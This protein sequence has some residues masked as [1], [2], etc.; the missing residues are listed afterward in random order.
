MTQAEISALLRK[1][2]CRVLR[3]HDWK[4]AVRTGAT[5]GTEKCRRCL[6]TRNVT[7]RKAAVVRAIARRDV[8]QGEL[9]ATND[10]DMQRSQW[11]VRT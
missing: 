10:V 7:L 1:F 6:A 9:V 8:E 5:T 3:G 11:P 4:R 2:S